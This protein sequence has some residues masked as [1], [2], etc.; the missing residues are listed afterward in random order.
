MIYML[1]VITLVGLVVDIILLVVKIHMMVNGI[2]LMTQKLLKFMILVRLLDHR[3]MY[4]STKEEFNM[5]IE[6]KKIKEI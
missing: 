5:T 2:T 3:H 1:L 4:Y 6:K